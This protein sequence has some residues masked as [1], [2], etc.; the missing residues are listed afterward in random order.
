MHNLQT[1][2]Q[3]NGQNIRVTDNLSIFTMIVNFN[4]TKS[5][6]GLYIEYSAKFTRCS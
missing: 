4:D 2:T 6:G 5:W 3:N 1:N